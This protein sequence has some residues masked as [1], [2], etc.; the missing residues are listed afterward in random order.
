V[1]FK[2]IAFGSFLSSLWFDTIDQK[3]PKVLLDKLSA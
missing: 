2:P 1:A 3:R